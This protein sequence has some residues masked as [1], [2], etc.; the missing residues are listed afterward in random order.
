MSIKQSREERHARMRLDDV[1]DAYK[2]ATGANRW[3]EEKKMFC[4]PNENPT[5]DPN[6]VAF[7]ALVVA[8]PTVGVWCKGLEE[9]PRY[10]E[11]V[12]EGIKKVIYASLDKKNM[13]EE[14]VDE[15][16][17][18]V[19]EVKKADEKA[20]EAVAE[21]QQVPKEQHNQKKK[22]ATVPTVEVTAQTDSSD[23]SIKI[24]NNAEQQCKKCMKT[25]SS[26][27]EKDEKFKIRDIEFTKKE[28]IF[29]EKS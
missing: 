11:K 14:I 3:S 16:Q 9:I 12:E 23:P 22:E 1:Y 4:Y 27:T 26:C 8:I 17:K 19:D 28:K 5:V 10:R 2:E 13:V 6:K 25:C 15:S 29:K 21:K 20:E 7:K 18:L 24:D